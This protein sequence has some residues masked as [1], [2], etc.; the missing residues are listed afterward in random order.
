MLPSKLKK[1]EESLRKPLVSAPIDWSSILIP[2]KFGIDEG[3]TCNRDGCIGEIH[4]PEPE[5]CSCHC[6]A[7]CGSCEGRRYQCNECGFRL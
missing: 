3:E 4:L 7:P 2:K 6:V 5:N 1:W